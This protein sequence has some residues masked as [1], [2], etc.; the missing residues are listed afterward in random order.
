MFSTDQNA[1]IKRK[2]KPKTPAPGFHLPNDLWDRSALPPLRPK[3]DDGLP[4]SGGQGIV[5]FRF[6]VDPQVIE[7]NPEWARGLYDNPPIPE[8]DNLLPHLTQVMNATV[9]QHLVPLVKLTRD[10]VHVPR[11][12][13]DQIHDMLQ[14]TQTASHADPSASEADAGTIGPMIEAF[15]S[16]QP[17]SDSSNINLD[18]SLETLVYMTQNSYMATN[19]LAN[20]LALASVNPDELK[21][22]PPKIWPGSSQ[23]ARKMGKRTASEAPGGAVEPVPKRVKGEPYVWNPGQEAPERYLNEDAGFVLGL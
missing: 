23:Q 18:L 14:T 12:P 6:H 4:V 9:Y 17:S 16:A 13:P 8:A 19:P 2:G 3:D 20:Q 7:A 10:S 22:P 15:H 5:L 1:R 11:F 21:P